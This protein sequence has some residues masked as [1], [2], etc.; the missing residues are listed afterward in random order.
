MKYLAII[1]SLVVLNSCASVGTANL[2]DFGNYVGLKPGVT[3]KT[4]VFDTFGQPAD[5]I[6]E[7]TPSNSPSKWI[8]V[9]A[10]MHVSGWSYVPYVGLLFGGVSE[11]N[12]V[13]KIKFDQKGYFKSLNTEKDTN[14]TNQWLGLT[15][16]AYRAAKDPKATRV[17]EEM[18]RLGKPF[19]KKFARNLAER[20]L[21]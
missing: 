12:M 14:Y 8:Y 2:E 9:K 13:A 6:Y 10:D 18:S 11:E 7:A 20:R 1:L 15:R 5:V 21:D 16:E 3:N 17:A 4:N 19:D